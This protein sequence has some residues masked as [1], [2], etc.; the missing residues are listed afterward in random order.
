MGAITVRRAGKPDVGA[1]AVLF[2][3]YRQFYDMPADA[4][5]A[6]AY[7]QARIEKSESVIFVAEEPESGEF[8][9]L[10]QLYPTFCSVFM[11]RIYVLYDLFVQPAA[12][13]SGTG[14]ALLAAAERHAAEN[15]AI[16]M[17]LRTARTNRPAQS[18]Y[19]SSGWRRDELFYGY[20]RKVSTPQLG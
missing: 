4:E 2:D 9:G 20:S 7:L 17:E 16:R 8:I 18:L 11:A 3:A 10:C 14:K 12:R 13:Q 15:G 1:L 5:R 6:R 19:E